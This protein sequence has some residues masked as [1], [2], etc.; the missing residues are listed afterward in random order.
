MQARQ[1]CAAPC[2]AAAESSEET[3]PAP[4]NAVSTAADD[5]KAEKIQAF[6][7][8][9]ETMAGDGQVILEKIR[10]AEYNGSPR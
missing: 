4:K 6:L 9:I 2:A 5:E 1:H 7:P 3:M 8:P 10:V